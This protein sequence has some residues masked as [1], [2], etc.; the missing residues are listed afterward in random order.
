MSSREHLFL[1]DS[2]K[3]PVAW[4]QALE[5][6]SE[7]LARLEDLDTRS[8]VPGPVHLSYLGRRWDVG[9]RH[10]YVCALGKWGVLRGLP[11]TVRVEGP[12]H[13]PT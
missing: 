2:L 6:N 1:E 13:E 9:W 10:M 12:H 7:F 4:G 3:V 8:A 11:L 5:V